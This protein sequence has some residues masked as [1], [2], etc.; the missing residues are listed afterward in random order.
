[1]L[2]ATRRSAWAGAAL[3]L[4][5]QPSVA[6]AQPDLGGFYIGT[7]GGGAFLEA[8]IVTP[9]VTRTTTVQ[10]TVPVQTPFGVQNRAVSVSVPVTLPSQRLRS[11][12]GSGAIFGGR[13][14]YGVLLDG[15]YYLGA[16][17]EVTFPQLAEM[18]LNLFGQTLKGSL[19]TEFGIHLRA[20]WTPNGQT[21]LFLRG[22]VAVPRQRFEIGTTTVERWAPTPAIGVGMEHLLASG[23][24]GRIDLGYYP[25]LE[26][27]QIGSFRGTL[28][29][30]YR[31]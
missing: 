13:A 24:S 19:D 2:S 22:G 11:Q 4:L 23:V 28:G 12:G 15:Q 16:E 3:G 14:G 31:F 1:M 20:G 25:A 10:T 7:F 17:V 6:M 18:R 26:D 27:N 5:M 9:A 29:I 30:G 21:L 8:D